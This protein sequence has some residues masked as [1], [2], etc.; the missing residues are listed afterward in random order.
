[1]DRLAQVRGSG[2]ELRPEEVHDH[3]AVDLVARLQGEQ[4]DQ[5]GR[6]PAAPGIDGNGVPVNPNLEAPQ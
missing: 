5:I 6:A 4:L 3:L 2:S 1:V